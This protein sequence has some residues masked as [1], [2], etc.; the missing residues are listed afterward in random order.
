ME[1]QKSA[2]VNCKSS[3]LRALHAEWHKFFE[4][5]P[6]PTEMDERAWRLAWTNKELRHKQ[7]RLIESWN[8][9]SPGQMRYLLKGLREASGDGANYRAVLIARLACE[10]FGPT[11]DRDLAEDLERRWRVRDPRRLTPAQAH[12]EIEELLSRIA[13]RD[14]VGIEE[15]RNR[16]SPPRH[17]ETKEA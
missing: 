8:Q 3:I 11:W 4:A 6:P 15:V 14:A 12:A 10:F 13:R 17:K 9:L 5:H 7:Q 2:I 1:D 16:F